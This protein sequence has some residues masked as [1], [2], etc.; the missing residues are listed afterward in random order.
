ME[1]KVNQAELPDPVPPALPAL[2]PLLPAAPALHRAKLQ[3]RK[4][5]LWQRVSFAIT[6]EQR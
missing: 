5:F 3:V 1:K 4:L 2:H 6:A